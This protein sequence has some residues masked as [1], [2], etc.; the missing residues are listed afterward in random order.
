MASP[1]ERLL[2]EYGGQQ[3]ANT[4]VV[5]HNG[6]HKHAA[7]YI[8]GAWVVSDEFKAILDGKTVKP[9]AKPKAKPAAKPEA[10]EDTSAADE[11]AND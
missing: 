5:R 6:K 3:V 9:K 11:V 2:K 10:A 7:R 8:S 1:V 4:I